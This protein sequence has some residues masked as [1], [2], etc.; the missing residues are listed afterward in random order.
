[1]YL[2][3]PQQ[4]VTLFPGEHPDKFVVHKEFACHYSPVLERAFNGDFIEGQKQ[5]YRFQDIGGEAV[6]LLVHWFY[7]QDLDTIMLD[8]LCTSKQQ[9]EG[10]AYPVSQRNQDRALAQLWVLAD[11]LLIPRLQNAVIDEIVRIKQHTNFATTKEIKYVFDNT[12]PSSC[13]RRLYVDSC[14]KNCIPNTKHIG[15]SARFPKE[16]LIEMVVRFTE[17]LEDTKRRSIDPCQN[18]TL[19]HVP[20]TLRPES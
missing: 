17:L 5:E 13:L 12:A 8:R 4:L 18:V 11:K 6:R 19:Y 3:M 16:L 1:M 15:D 2:R 20:E 10:N 14:I 9:E 7:T